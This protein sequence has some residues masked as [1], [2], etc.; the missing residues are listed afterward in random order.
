MARLFSDEGKFFFDTQEEPPFIVEL[1]ENNFYGNM[2]RE[3]PY[4]D[5]LA[6]EDPRDGLSWSWWRCDQDPEVFDHMMG[7]CL[8]IGSLLMRS[9][10]FENVSDLF[11][12]A[13]QISDTEIEGLLGESDG[14]TA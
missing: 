11:D 12:N 13:H 9:T 3:A 6:I 1:N 5:R 4:M 14:S 8:E 2:H 10:P 7:V